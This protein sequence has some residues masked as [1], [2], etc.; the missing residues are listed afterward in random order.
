MKE[1]Q[2][3]NEQWRYRKK[4]FIHTAKS[5]VL[6]LATEPRLRKLKNKFN[7]QIGETHPC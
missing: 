2:E 3:K 4:M 6:L 1:D 7:I 5:T